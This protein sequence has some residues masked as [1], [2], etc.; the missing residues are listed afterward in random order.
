MITLPDNSKIRLEYTQGQQEI[1]VP[2]PNSGVFRY[3]I[4]AFIVCWLGGWAFGWKSAATA[5][6]SGTKGPELF[7]LF[8]LGAWTVGGMFAIYFVYR[9]FR[10]SVP[11]KMILSYGTMIYDS[12]IP[13]LRISFSFGSQMD[14]WRKMFQKR[15]KTEFDRSQLKTLRLREF[16]SGNR[17]TI[18]QGSKRYELAVEA[19]EPEREWL[20]KVLNEHYNS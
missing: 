5:L 3:F 17:L 10:P 18:D 20:F 9:I 11:E 14:V 19:S 6:L 4:G 8:W 13:P 15:I 12:G 7:L 16:D 1:I 2:Q